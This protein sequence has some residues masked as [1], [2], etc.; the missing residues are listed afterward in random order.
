ME[1]FEFSINAN[2]VWIM[3][4]KEPDLQA[5]EQAR[6]LLNQLTDQLILEKYVSIPAK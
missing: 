1:E 2:G 4:E 5:I 6:Q 3:F